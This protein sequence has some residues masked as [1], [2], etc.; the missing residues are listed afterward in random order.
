MSTAPLSR[1]RQGRSRRVRLSG[2]NSF[3]ISV[4]TSA[5]DAYLDQL[6]DAAEEAVRPVAQA[7]A[8]VFYERVRLN[9]AAMGKKTGNLAGS[10]YQVYSKS[11]SADGVKATYHVS[12][13]HVKAPHGHLLEYGYIKQWKSYLAKN[14]KWY[15][16]KNEPLEGGPKQI[17]GAAF[18]RRAVAA[19]PE[20]V[21]AGRAELIRRLGFSA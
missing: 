13:N 1:R 17:P 7:M 18:V 11:Q 14:G 8:Q 12:W 6:G 2:K 3:D 21:E 19:Q 16:L 15:T 9:V 20:A 5:L 10:I 4:D